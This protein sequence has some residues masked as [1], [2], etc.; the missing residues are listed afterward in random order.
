MGEL[1]PGRNTA[2]QDQGPREAAARGGA[3][4]EPDRGGCGGAGQGGRAL[5][6][7]FNSRA[8][9]EE[10]QAREHRG[11]RGVL[12]LPSRPRAPAALPRPRTGPAHARCLTGQPTPN[13]LRPSSFPVPLPLLC[14]RWPQRPPGPPTRAPRPVP[15]DQLRAGSTNSPAPACL[16]L[17]ALALG[18]FALPVSGARREHD[19]HQA[20]W[21]AGGAWL[22][23][24][25]L[26]SGLVAVQVP[27]GW[28]MT[29]QPQR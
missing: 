7:H 14:Q 25:W 20:A 27:S 17:F 13:E 22:C 6:D 26:P 8:A 3:A 2:D 4:A 29:R 1:R 19:R 21:L 15:G 9:R 10:Q 24:V 16:G 28:S 23:R 11:L 12:A 5:Q 18:L